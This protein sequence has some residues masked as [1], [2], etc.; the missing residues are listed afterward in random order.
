[1]C[2][3]AQGRR[4]LISPRAGI[5]LLLGAAALCGLAHTLIEA[6]DAVSLVST[7]ADDQSPAVLQEDTTGGSW[8]R[9]AV[10]GFWT[11]KPEDA[12]LKPVRDED[13]VSADKAPKVKVDIYME[14]ACPGCQFFT[15]H[16]LVPV[17][18]EE[19]MAGITDL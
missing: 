16:V 4:P 15:T 18:Q 14:A 2:C 3:V 10:S 1:V 19:G 13:R 11:T 5:L 12:P 8:I 17:M 7:S 6:D 9:D